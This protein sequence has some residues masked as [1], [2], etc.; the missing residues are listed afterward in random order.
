MNVGA[1]FVVHFLGA[2]VPL[3][4]SSF[5]PAA[6]NKLMERYGA[7]CSAPSQQPHYGLLGY[8]TVYSGYERFGESAI[9]KMKTSDLSETL[10]TTFQVFSKHFN[11]LVNYQSVKRYICLPSGRSWLHAAREPASSMSSAVRNDECFH[12][13]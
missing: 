5:G 1:K 2:T 8:S 4:T 3:P 12:P 9:L 6:L 10:L 7:E 11:S 13:N